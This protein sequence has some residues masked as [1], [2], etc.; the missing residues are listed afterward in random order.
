MDHGGLGKA[1]LR[2]CRWCEKH[3]HYHGY[4]YPCE[5]YDAATLDQIREEDELFHAALDRL[6]LR[7]TR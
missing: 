4:L 1:E 6:A 2:G 7:R 3:H 5:F